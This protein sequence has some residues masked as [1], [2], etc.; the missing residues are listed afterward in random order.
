MLIWGSCKSAFKYAFSLFTLLCL[1]IWASKLLNYPTPIP[2]V[3]DQD[4]VINAVW[5]PLFVGFSFIF[6]F[7][8]FLLLSIVF[9]LRGKL[10]K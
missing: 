2:V 1:L 8:I 10:R 3:Y 9:Y 6:S 4:A 5:R 7:F